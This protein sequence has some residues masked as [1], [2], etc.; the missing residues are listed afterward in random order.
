MDDE[1]SRAMPLYSL[2]QSTTLGDDEM[3]LDRATPV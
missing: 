2:G 3:K 1:F